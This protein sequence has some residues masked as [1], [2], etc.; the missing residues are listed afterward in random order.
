MFI[1][2]IKHFMMLFDSRQHSRNV[3][4]S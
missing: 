3:I 4:S 2:A 1:S